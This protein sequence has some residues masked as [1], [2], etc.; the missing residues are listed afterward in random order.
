MVKLLELGLATEIMPKPA[1]ALFTLP[2]AMGGPVPPTAGG[3]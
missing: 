2:R 1:A 3:Y